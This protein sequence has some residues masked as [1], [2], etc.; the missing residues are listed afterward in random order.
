[1]NRG[2]ARSPHSS[3]MPARG[4]PVCM[5]MPQQTARRLLTASTRHPNH[6]QHPTPTPGTPA[7]RQCASAPEPLLRLP[8]VGLRLLLRRRQVRPVHRHAHC[9]HVGQQAAKGQPG[10]A[11]HIP[12]GGYPHARLRR[13]VAGRQRVKHWM[14]TLK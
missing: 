4:A 5:Q 12:H 3:A 9:L 2:N 7:Q 6:P 13:V 11:V 14:A 1:M 8:L 10:A